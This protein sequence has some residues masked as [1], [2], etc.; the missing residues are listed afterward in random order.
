MCITLRRPFIR[1]AINEKKAGVTPAFLNFTFLDLFL[2]TFLD[3][4][5]EFYAPTHEKWAG[6]F[7]LPEDGF[8]DLVAP[9]EAWVHL[10]KL[11]ADRLVAQRTS[12]G[13]GVIVARTVGSGR[14]VPAQRTHTFGLAFGASTCADRVVGIV[15]VD[16]E[17]HRAKRA[18][19]VSVRTTLSRRVTI[20]GAA[21]FRI[22]RSV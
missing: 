6:C 20:V 12:S 14:L 19:E 17:S 21:D 4:F 3:L 13:V 18:L 10:A 1:P 8:S 7:L 11:V 16:V 5:L 22:V 15:E 9:W 2:E